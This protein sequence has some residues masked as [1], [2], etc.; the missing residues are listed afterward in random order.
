MNA[1]ARAGD[2]LVSPAHGRRDCEGEMFNPSKV[3]LATARVLV[4]GAIAA[5][6]ARAIWFF[7]LGPEPAQL[8]E[9]ARPA[10]SSG[11]EVMDIEQIAALNLFGTPTSGAGGFNVDAAPDTELDL[12]LL[13]IFL[14]GQ[15]D[16]SV[17]I[18]GSRGDAGQAYREGDPIFGNAKVAEIRRDVVL[19]SRAGLME[20]LRF[21]DESTLTFNQGPAATL[22]KRIGTRDAASGFAVTGAETPNLTDSVE[23]FRSRLEQDP[24]GTLRAVGLE[25]VSIEGDTVYRIGRS[26]ASSQLGRT[27]LQPG[28]TILSIDGQSLDEVRQ[29]P[30]AF[31]ALL[32]KGSARLEIQRGKRRFF[33]TT[34]L[35]TLIQL[36]GGHREPA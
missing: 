7:A 8:V 23:A 34:S 16:T 6:L 3:L 13:G 11:P 1:P 22:E 30:E 5:T 33:L 17:A 24:D 21:A 31:A 20:A 9:S 15:P 26:A 27:G 14:A 10:A 19:I 32:S 36:A 29:S 4:I 2:I 18:I 12:E 35:A 28:D 25:P